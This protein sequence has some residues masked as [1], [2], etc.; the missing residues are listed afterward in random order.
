[1]H[2][3]TMYTELQSVS[4]QL[5]RRDC[6]NATEELEALRGVDGHDP[7]D[8]VGLLGHVRLGLVGGGA[9]LGEPAGER[10]QAA[11]S[12][13][14]ERAGRRSSGGQMPA[15]TPRTGMVELKLILGIVV[16]GVSAL[17]AVFYWW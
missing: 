8:L 13:G 10:A 17:R 14:A 5:P 3:S 7:G 16:A 1:M 6:R 12:G 15:L 2:R 9:L 4:T 11:G